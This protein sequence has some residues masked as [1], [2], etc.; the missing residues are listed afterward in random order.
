[1]DVV[2]TAAAK[3]ER[4]VVSSVESWDPTRLVLPFMVRCNVHVLLGTFGSN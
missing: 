3:E 4:F 1:M 2:M